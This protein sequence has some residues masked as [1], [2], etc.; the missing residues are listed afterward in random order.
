MNIGK[1]REQHLIQTIATVSPDKSLD[2]ISVEANTRD[3]H[4]DIDL[5]P[6]SVLEIYIYKTPK[7][8]TS[9]EPHRIA[10]GIHRKSRDVSLEHPGDSHD[11][12][13]VR[14]SL[15]HVP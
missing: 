2:E 14:Q 7:I 15:R 8:C 6:R 1:G 5:K 12:I 13:L 11:M 9:P 4:Q 10:K 3:L